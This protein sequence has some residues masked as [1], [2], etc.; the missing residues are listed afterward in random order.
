MVL[1]G[2]SWENHGKMCGWISMNLVVTPKYVCLWAKYHRQG[3]YSC[4]MVWLAI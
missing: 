2:K 1:M 3:L 4:D